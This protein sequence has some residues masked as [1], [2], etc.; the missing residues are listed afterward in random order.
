MSGDWVIVDD[1]NADTTDSV[2]KMIQR[3]VNCMSD[4]SKITRKRGLIDLKKETIARKLGGT[5][6]QELSNEILKPTL[7]CL[8]DPS[9]KNRELATDLISNY[10]SVIPA[11]DETLPYVMM[12]LTQRLGQQEIV[13]PSEELRLQLLESILMPCIELSGKKI[14]GYLD[15][16]IA[17]LQRTIVDPFAEVRKISCKIACKFSRS[18]PE[19]FHM[20]SASLIKPL[21]TSITH[22]HSKVTTVESG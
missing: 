13:E 15:E 17:I 10:L 12:T 22:Q 1:N 19:H 11:P 14:A 7:K 8:S 4:N 16:V 2:R 20:Q 6:L 5:L 18:V 21:M 9:E 3:H